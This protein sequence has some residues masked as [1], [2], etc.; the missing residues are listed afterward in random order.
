MKKN[1]AEPDPDQ[2]MDKLRQKT[3]CQLKP[4]SGP[5]KALITMWFFDP[6]SQTCKVFGYGGCKGNLNKFDTKD[7]CDN[8]CT[9]NRSD[10]NLSGNGIGS[11][12]A[13]S[14]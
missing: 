12:V 14:G 7:E 1:K 13:S 5:C 4:E 10:T 2:N 6:Q 8:F 11:N 3:D 9:G